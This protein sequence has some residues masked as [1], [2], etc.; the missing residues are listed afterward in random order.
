M[1]PAKRKE[2]TFK[3]FFK[4]LNVK[5]SPTFSA[6]PTKNSGFSVVSGNVATGSNQ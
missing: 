4:I 2:K 1:L 3:S 5:T 6:N